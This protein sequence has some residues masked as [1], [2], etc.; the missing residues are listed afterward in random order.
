MHLYNQTHYIHMYLHYFFT[1]KLDLFVKKNLSH[2]GVYRKMKITIVHSRWRV[3]HLKI[4]NFRI[5]HLINSIQ[6]S[7]YLAHCCTSNNIQYAQVV[8][9][10]AEKHTSPYICYGIPLTA[11][12]SKCKLAVYKHEYIAQL[13]THK[14]LIIAHSKPTR[15]SCG[16]L[17]VN[18]L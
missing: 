14:N 13:P 8:P 9:P 17:N 3:R 15:T 5:L 10:E 7:T 12:N 11:K 18:G 2:S 1:S 6:T 4:Y 16:L